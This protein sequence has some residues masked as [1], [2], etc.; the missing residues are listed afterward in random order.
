MVI[1][2]EIEIARERLLEE[3][4]ADK[5]VFFGANFNPQTGELVA[6]AFDY[7][8]VPDSPTPAQDWDDFFLGLEFAEL[9]IWCEEHGFSCAKEGQGVSIKERK[10]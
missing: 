9:V 4:Q 10:R 2:T 7:S 8:P 6:T 5:N 3:L 1:T